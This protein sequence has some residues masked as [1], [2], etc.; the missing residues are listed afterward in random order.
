M[1]TPADWEI[2]PFSSG[3]EPATPGFTPSLKITKLY[4]LWT[5]KFDQ[6]CKTE[7]QF[8]LFRKLY[9]KLSPMTSSN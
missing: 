5:W 2:K 3:A 9:P 6:S 7:V 4:E 8:D 1:L